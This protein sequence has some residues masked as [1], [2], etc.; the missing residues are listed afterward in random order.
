MV[1]A[2]P[3]GYAQPLAALGK[4][5]FASLPTKLLFRKALAARTARLPKSLT[6]LR[7]QRSGLLRLALR[8]R[9]FERVYVDLKKHVTRRRL[10]KEILPAP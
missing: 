10:A 8:R 2:P 9:K 7:S 6:T 3:K 5:R 1:A 4:R